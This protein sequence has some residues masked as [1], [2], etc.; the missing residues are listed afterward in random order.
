MAHMRK[1]ILKDK[2]MDIIRKDNGK[3]GVFMA[4][5][6]DS[7]MG[8]MTYAW[9]NDNLII[10]DHTG[11]HPTYEGQGVGKRL[12]LEAIAFARQSNIRIIPSCSFVKVMFKRMPETHDV[13]PDK[14]GD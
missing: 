4:L 7:Q 5:E 6:D 13:L 8:E 14:Q 9:L 11:V 12:F 10:I 1:T 3:R 2:I